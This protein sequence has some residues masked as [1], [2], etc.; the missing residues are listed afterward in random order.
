MYK[1]KKSSIF[2]ELGEWKNGIQGNDGM[3][4]GGEREH[5]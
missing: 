1:Y 5:S 2:T 4:C 3:G